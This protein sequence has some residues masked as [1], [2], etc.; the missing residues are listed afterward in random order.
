M[1]RLELSNQVPGSMGS[2]NGNVVRGKLQ[3]LGFNT[4]GIRL[5]PRSRNEERGQVPSSRLLRVGVETGV[6]SEKTIAPGCRGSRSQ[7]GHVRRHATVACSSGRSTFECQRSAGRHNKRSPAGRPSYFFDRLDVEEHR[8]GGQWQ[9]TRLRRSWWSLPRQNRRGNSGSARQ[10]HDTDKSNQE[11]GDPAKGTTDLVGKVATTV[12]LAGNV[13]A[14]T[15]PTKA[16]NGRVAGQVQSDRG[17]RGAW[18]DG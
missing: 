9:R 3:K 6:D 11:D 15:D 18:W 8:Q 4:T 14:A 7:G 5:F 13:V 12:N 10:G 1:L 16:M 17:Q 2:R